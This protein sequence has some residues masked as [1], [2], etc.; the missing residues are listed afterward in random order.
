MSGIVELV[1]VL[2][3]LL[4]LF[5]LLIFVL[6]LV[7]ILVLLLPIA[8]LLPNILRLR[9]PPRVRL[10]RAPRNW[11]RADDG[12]VLVEL[13][14]AREGPRALRGRD[15][16]AGGDVLLLVVRVLFKL[17]VI[18]IV[19]YLELLLNSISMSSQI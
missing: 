11:S 15:R 10:A 8:L 5:L 12:A 6:L 17:F 4:R 3:V 7:L 14:R 9:R 1:R 16:A 13:D 19:Q 2:L 18:S